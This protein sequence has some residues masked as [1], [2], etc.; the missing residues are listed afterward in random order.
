M[1]GKEEIAQNDI[2]HV[3]VVNDSSSIYFDLVGDGSFVSLFRSKEHL[4]KCLKKIG[5]VPDAPYS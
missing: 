3:W 1:I 5:L 4:K 2:C